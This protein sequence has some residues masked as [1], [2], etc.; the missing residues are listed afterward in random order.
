MAGE[1]FY[2]SDSFLEAF[3]RPD[4]DEDDA[5]MP[6][7]RQIAPYL[8]YGEPRSASKATFVLPRG[9][10]IT[11]DGLD[12]ALG[13][14]LRADPGTVQTGAREVGEILIRD[15]SKATGLA[16]VAA[17]LDVPIADTVAIGDSTNDMEVLSAAGVS[18]AM[19]NAPDEIKAIATSV[20]EGNDADG[21]YHFLRKVLV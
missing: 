8:D 13:D 5:W 9:S 2:A 20:T 4:E 21:I 10:D 12:R 19:G 3:T 14:S 18:V 15:V 6:Y 17:Y 1:V 11:I 16:D 7:R